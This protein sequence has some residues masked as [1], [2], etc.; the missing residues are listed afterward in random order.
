MKLK[1]RA[2]AIMVGTTISMA[3]VLMILTVD[4]HPVSTFYQ[5]AKVQSVQGGPVV[6]ETGHGRDGGEDHPVHLRRQLGK[7]AS[8]SGGKAANLTVV[9]HTHDLD[10][11]SDTAVQHEHSK[12]AA[13]RKT[14][15]RTSPDGAAKP[16]NLRTRRTRPKGFPDEGNFYNS[17][18]KW[19]RTQP[20][21]IKPNTGKYDKLMSLPSATSVPSNADKLVRPKKTKGKHDLKIWETFQLSINR[22]EVYSNTSG[23]DELLEYLMTQP[24]YEVDEKSGGTQVKLIL[25]FED[26]GHALFKPWRVS[27]EYETLPNHFYFSDIERHNAEIAAFHLD[28]I[29]D[30]RRAPPVAGRW[31]NLTSDI[32]DLADSGLRKTFFRSPANNIC[33]VGHCSYYCETETAVCGKPDMIEGS[34]AAY[35][36][37]F[38]AA[39]RKTWRHPW[40]RSYSK[41][42]T[43]IWEQ[44]P[45]YCERSVMTK[46][47]YKTGRRL[48]D[49]MDMS[50]FDYLIGNMDRHHYETF[51]AFGNFTFPIH[52]DHGRAFGKHHHDELSILA[53]LF[54]CCLLRESTYKRLQLLASEEYQ[55]SDVM[56]ESL[57]R[58]MIFPVLLEA[59]VEAMDRRLQTILAQVHRCFQRKSK[60]AVL[61]PE[62]RLEDYREPEPSAKTG[63]NFDEEEY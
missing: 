23:I 14:N 12:E 40:R 57:S 16:N 19:L 46:H 62:P 49:L 1:Q 63:E 6:V 9:R 48:L 51:E 13:Y 18:H 53:P 59:H 8:R 44:D 45:T 38:K 11:L 54:Q 37:S 10:S 28:R 22:F 60:E 35:L 55:L 56:R 24:I 17:D 50:V 36:P 7:S 52:L 47:P 4:L 42:R 5:G 39:P 27:R 15:S 2:L 21:H 29:L 61:R 41:H 34:V 3:L 26:G 32:Y 25:T 30:F 43:A 58:D 33:F 20:E 31:F